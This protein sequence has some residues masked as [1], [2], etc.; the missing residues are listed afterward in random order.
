MF[1]PGYE[2]V[3]RQ[4]AVLVD[5]VLSPA[6]VE[7]SSVGWFAILT[8]ALG[9][10]VALMA[11]A[12]SG[13]AVSLAAMAWV[14][15]AA[16]AGAFAV[17]TFGAWTAGLVSDSPGHGELVDGARLRLVPPLQPGVAWLC[18][19]FVSA[20][21]YWVLA[22]VTPAPKNEPPAELEPDAQGS[23]AVRA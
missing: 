10:A 11:Y 17:H 3:V 8:A 2:A 15:V 14:V 4:D 1:R 5:R 19:P 6:S 7:F 21:A 9:L 16:A 18:A 12:R 13:G 23:A 20:L 22:L